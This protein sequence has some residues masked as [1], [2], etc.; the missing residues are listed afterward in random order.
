MKPVRALLLQI[1]ENRTFAGC[2]SIGF[3]LF[4]WWLITAGLGLIRPLFLPSPAE[5]WAAAWDLMNGSANQV[6]GGNLFYQTAVSTFRVLLGFVIAC[7]IAVPL[8]VLAGLSRAADNLL[9]PIMQV[10]QPIPPIAWTPLAIV[11]FGL[12]LKAMLFLI[13]IASFVSMFI[14][15]VVG[16][17]EVRPVFARVAASLGG[18]RLQT[19]CLVI[20]PAAAPMLF[21]GLRLS[22]GRAWITIIAAELIAA[23]SGLGYMI[24]N[25]RTI[26]ATGDVIT[27]MVV[28]GLI[29][30][31]FDRLLLWFERRIYAH[32]A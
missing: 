23:S 28:I 2:L 22:F 30:A 24:M 14:N 17:R 9:E 16:V 12:N 31:M 18:S 6:Y 1:V 25:A 7:L 4:V 20:L 27:G 10:L 13:V 19:I 15:T 8:G 5:T 26:L 21:T 3:V 32:R 29:G 11:W